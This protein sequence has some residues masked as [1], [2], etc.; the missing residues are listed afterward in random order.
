MKV[1]INKDIHWYWPLTEWLTAGIMAGTYYGATF[2]CPK[3]IALI[4]AIAI[5]IFIT[6]GSNENGLCHFIDAFAMGGSDRRKIITLMKSPHVNSYGAVGIAI[7]L[8]LLYNSLFIMNKSTAALTIFVADPFAKM[9]SSQLV[10]MMPH[11][12]TEGETTSPRAINIRSSIVLAVQGLLPLAV[13]AYFGGFDYVDW[14]VM[15]FVPATVMYFIYYF[16]WK[17]LRSYTSECQGATFLLVELSIYITI[18][19]QFYAQQSVK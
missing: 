14:E 13:Y 15:L 6:H 1:D 11:A 10:M 4:L 7:Y 2:V 19:F 12:T 8:L 18:I 5:R 16:V 17:R 3:E 9:L